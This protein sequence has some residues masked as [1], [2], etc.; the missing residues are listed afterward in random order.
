MGTLLLFIPWINLE[1]LSLKI[2]LI[3]YIAKIV[4]YQNLLVGL[5]YWMLAVV[6]VFYLR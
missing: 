6:V 3:I 1:S 2:L 4:P 5:E